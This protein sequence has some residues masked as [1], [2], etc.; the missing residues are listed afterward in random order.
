LKEKS[1]MKNAILDLMNSYEKI[2][3][4]LQNFTAFDDI[5]GC[6]ENI[7]SVDKE[8]EKSENRLQ[9]ILAKNCSL[10]KKD[11]NSMMEKILWDVENKEEEIQRKQKQIRG[12]LRNYLDEQRKLATVLKERLTQFIQGKSNEDGFK[13]V[14]M[15]IKTL[16]ENKGQ[17]VLSRLQDFK[18]DLELFRKEQEV[19]NRKLQRLIDRGKSLRIE[20]LRRLECTKAR[21]R[22]EAERRILREDVERLLCHF[23]QQRRR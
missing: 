19:V 13:T 4:V 21:E 6:D 20:D 12:M 15:N 2:I 18:F 11:F 14:L 22:R 10:R 8:R 16:Q 7:V 17:Q 23:K 5:I 3:S 1:K 9:E